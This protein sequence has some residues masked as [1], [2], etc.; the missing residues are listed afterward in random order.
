MRARPATAAL[1]GA[2]AGVLVLGTLGT[3][4]A[5]EVR[6]FACA[7]VQFFEVVPCAT[8]APV[9]LSVSQALPAPEVPLFSPETMAA[10]TP[11]LLVK[12]LDEPSVEH[13]R[14]FVA[15]QLRRQQRVQEV[16]QL[17]KAIAAEIPR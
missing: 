6:Y 2:L 11:P 5:Q 8:P 12:V 17:L 16:Q 13:A 9:P 10:D 14:A 15:W 7:E 3:S 1:H 4:L